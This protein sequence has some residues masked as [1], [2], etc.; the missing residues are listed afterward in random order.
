MKILYK[1]HT[2]VFCITPDM[3]TGSDVELLINGGEKEC[4]MVE[5]ILKKVRKQAAIELWARYELKPIEIICDPVSYSRESQM[6]FIGVEANWAKSDLRRLDSPTFITVTYFI[7]AVVAKGSKEINFI[8]LKHPDYY[9]EYR[10]ED[11]DDI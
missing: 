11:C 7:K 6:D 8:K 1:P 9:S 2:V 10:V 5:C 4:L 3:F